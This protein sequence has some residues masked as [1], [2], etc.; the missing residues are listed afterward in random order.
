MET[1]VTKLT[2]MTYKLTSE[3]ELSVLENYPH[4]KCAC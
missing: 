4:H 3:K 1:S 2:W